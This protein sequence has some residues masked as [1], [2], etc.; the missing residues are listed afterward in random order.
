MKAAL[1]CSFSL[2]QGHARCTNIWGPYFFLHGCLVNRDVKDSL[3]DWRHLR[4][5][6]LVCNLYQWMFGQS[7]VYGFCHWS[8][9]SCSP[10]RG[11]RPS[12]VRGVVHF[13]SLLPCF[14]SNA[15]SFDEFGIWN[16]HIYKDP[17]SGTI[18]SIK[19]IKIY[20]Y[21]FDINLLILIF[22]Y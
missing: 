13:W 7:K 18:N 20:Q 9:R 19:F 4:F 2:V 3:G 5:C 14:G 8:F 12:H 22:W 21:I 6:P 11:H 17:S 15:A 16:S 1:K 10:F